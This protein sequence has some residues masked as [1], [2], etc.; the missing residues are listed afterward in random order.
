MTWDMRIPFSFQLNS[1][2]W[3]AYHRQHFANGDNDHTVI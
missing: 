2:A 3:S 1:N